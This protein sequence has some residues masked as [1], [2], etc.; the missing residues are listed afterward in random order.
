MLTQQTITRL[1]LILGILVVVNIISIRVFTR[2]DLTSTKAYTLSEAS[3]NLVRSLDDKFLVKAYFTSDLPSPYNNH[4]R[5]VQDQLDDFRAYGKGKFE[6]EFIDPSNKPE[7]EQEAQRYAVPPVQVQ[8]IKNDKMQIEKAYMGL[9]FLYGDKQERLPVVQSLD[10]LEFDISSN[11]KKLTSK[12][13]NK[14]G[15]LTGHTE[16]GL[17]KMEEFR[18]TLSNKYEVTTVDLS[19]DKAVPSDV[20]ALV[21]V[22]PRKKFADWEKYLIDQYV[23]RGRRAAF[24]ID[25]VD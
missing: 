7:I 15:F 21:I 25:K 22:S 4:R 16:P 13:L 10:K 14:I 18:Q 19:G 20:S 24:F 11:L 23:M 8:V 3:K 12:Q 2:L 17:D 9:V 5:F 1:L 6:Y